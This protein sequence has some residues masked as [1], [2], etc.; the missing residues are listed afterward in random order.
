MS[1]TTLAARIEAQLQDQ[2]R[3]MFLPAR[4][5]ATGNVVAVHDLRVATRRLRVS[6]RY[7]AALFPPSELRQIQRQLRRATR[8]LGAI[9]AHDVNLQL[10]RRA[11]KYLPVGTAAVQRKLTG[12]FLAARL[13]HVRDLRDLL[14]T[15]ATSQ[16]EAHIRALVLKPRR[17]D[18]R[19]VVADAQD[20]IAKLRRQLRRR[21]KNCRPAARCGPV[22][23]KLRVTAKRYR[24][25]LET[26]GA[27][28]RTRA[29]TPVSALKELQNHL[30]ACHDVE[31]LLDCLR[32]SR[33]QWTKADNPLASRL[34][35]VLTFFQG[36]HEVAFADV[37]KFLRD[38]HGW[39]KKVRLLLPHD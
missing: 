38:E 21:F 10:L 4:A 11:A 12:E 31:V 28:F 8:T 9:R 32:A 23:H 33:R 17:H 6:L 27:V 22:F 3:A 20:F 39:H 1:L 16:F 5:A 7:F 34:T 2:L 35:S 19:R 26:S 14:Q 13:E 30:G 15:F 37:Q 18:D 25:A 29:A 24:Y 36:E